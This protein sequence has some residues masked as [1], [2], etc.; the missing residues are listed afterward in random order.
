MN[1]I[2]RDK[3]VTWVLIEWL[4]VSEKDSK[5]ERGEI[6]KEKKGFSGGATILAVKL[7][8]VEEVGNVKEP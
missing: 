2:K 3:K 4:W 8:E 1:T 5:R 7:K 6:K